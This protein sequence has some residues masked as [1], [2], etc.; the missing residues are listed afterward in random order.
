MGNVGQWG[1]RDSSHNF[2]TKKLNTCT[3]MF[4][5]VVF[6][7]RS[8]WVWVVNDLR[9]HSASSIKEILA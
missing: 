2:S 3:E 4:A 5:F 7:E 9:I 1:T 8:E 6:V